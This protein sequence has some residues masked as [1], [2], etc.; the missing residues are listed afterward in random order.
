MYFQSAVFHELRQSRTAFQRVINRLTGHP[1]WQSPSLDPLQ[2][3]VQPNQSGSRLPNLDSW[4][5]ALVN[6][7]PFTFVDTN[8]GQFKQRFYRS[9]CLP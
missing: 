2:G 6:T 7:V 4:T 1:L 3:A 5:S 8:A 9:F